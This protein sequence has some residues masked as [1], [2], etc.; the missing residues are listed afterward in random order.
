MAKMTEEEKLGLKKVYL[1][2]LENIAKTLSAPLIE[3]IK[4]AFANLP[5]P[6]DE[7]LISTSEH[8]AKCAECR[9][10]YNF[11]VGKTW[12]ETLDAESYGW[13]SH[14][15]SFFL[16]LAWQYYLPAYLIQ[17]IN[18]KSFPTLY[19]RRDEDPELVEFEENRIK[20]LTSWQCDVIIEYLEIADELGQGLIIYEEYEISKTLNYWKENYRKALAKEQ[21]LN[22]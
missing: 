14:A 19:F 10:L 16:P 15:Q 8:R 12:Q 13:L 20:L 6:N 1:E 4:E 17:I 5:Y 9:G 21:N 2:R 22:E 11:F 7:N 18:D 3:N